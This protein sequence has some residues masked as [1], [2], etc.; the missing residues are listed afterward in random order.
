[1]TVSM[2]IEPDLRR[3]K[4]EKLR[5]LQRKQQRVHWQV[6]E[7]QFDPAFPTD[8]GMTPVIADGPAGRNLALGSSTGRT[9]AGADR[10]AGLFEQSN[11]FDTALD[12]TTCPLEQHCP[13]HTA[14]TR[15]RLNSGFF[16]GRGRH[17][18]TRCVLVI[19]L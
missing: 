1:R 15:P 11:D 13:S 12:F 8:D 7:L 10:S 2:W 19:E 9:D 4:L 5:P 17:T 18:D 3:G 16:E 6:V 14:V